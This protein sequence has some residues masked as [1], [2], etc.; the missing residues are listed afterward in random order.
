MPLPL[1]T[2]ART[3]ARTLRRTETEDEGVG[4]LLYKGAPTPRPSGH[5]PLSDISAQGAVF[6][7]QE[8]PGAPPRRIGVLPGTR[9][10]VSCQA[11]DLVG[12]SFQRARE[13]REER[14]EREADA[15]RA[16]LYLKGLTAN[17]PPHTRRAS[18]A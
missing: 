7:A 8:G 11:Q 10:L 4:A 14:E 12:A 6:K 3:H 16:S 1:R 17:P 5:G 15:P 13:E 18:R 9:K 2:H